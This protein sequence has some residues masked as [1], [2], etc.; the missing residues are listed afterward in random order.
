[1]TDDREL[2]FDGDGN[3]GYLYRHVNGKAYFVKLGNR[4]PYISIPLGIKRE[5]REEHAEQGEKIISEKITS[6]DQ[7]KKGEPLSVQEAL[8]G[9]NPHYQDGEE[10]KQN[11]NR[12]VQ[13]Y[14]FRRR[15]Y[16]VIA[17]GNIDDKI[18]YG[19]ECFGSGERFT[20]G[21]SKTD[22]Y[23]LL[24]D[25]EDGSRY[26]IYFKWRDKEDDALKAH[27]FIAEKVNKKIMYI[28]PQSGDDDCISFF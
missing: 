21:K 14:E 6:F 10:Y 25:A 23:K 26:S 28:D 17:R 8:K 19:N 13:A 11:C 2:Q 3:P 16:N 18:K 20:F 22:V 1:M 24:E 12:C 27:V 4:N 9:A 7:L 5:E 15:G